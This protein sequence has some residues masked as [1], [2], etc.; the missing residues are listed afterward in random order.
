MQYH[1]VHSYFL[2]AIQ[3]NKYDTFS[4]YTGVF[5]GDGVRCLGGGVGTR[6]GGGGGGVGAR[7][8]G[9]C[10]ASGFFSTTVSK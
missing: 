8:V 7:G 5:G 9:T 10:T 2:F 6:G 1:R 4:T 3:N